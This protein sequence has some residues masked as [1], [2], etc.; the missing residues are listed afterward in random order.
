M[1]KMLCEID[2]EK[3]RGI[4]GDTFSPAGRDRE[5]IVELGSGLRGGYKYKKRA[6]SW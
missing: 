5:S 2:L 3:A 6:V 1:H 4:R